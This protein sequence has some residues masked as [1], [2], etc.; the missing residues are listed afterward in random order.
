MCPDG[1]SNCARGGIMYVRRYVRATRPVF[2][3]DDNRLAQ[4][5]MQWK[6][7]SPFCLDIGTYYSHYLPVHTIRVCNQNANSKRAANYFVLPHE[8][9]LLLF[10][11]HIIRVL[12][13]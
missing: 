10:M 1:E 7:N 5:S 12:L 6:D 9:C 13:I 8:L 11:L 4:Y 3:F 2:V